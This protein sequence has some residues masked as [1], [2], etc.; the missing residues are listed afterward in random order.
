MKAQG[1]IKA[2]LGVVMGLAGAVQAEAHFFPSTVPDLDLSRYVGKWY[3]VESTQPFFQKGCVCNTA[4]YSLRDDGKI[5][6]VNSCNDTLP[7]GHVRVFEAIGAPS[8]EPGKLF[9]SSG[10]IPTFVPNYWVVD[11]ASDY[12]YAVVSSFVRT[13]IWILSRT[14]E[15]SQETRAA[16]YERLQKNGF[17]PRV[18]TPTLQEGCAH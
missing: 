2:L 12:S 18:L 14:P 15:I 17:D 8:A 13:P 6:I 11:V 4:E 1:F 16:I 3:E 10:G 7:E 9:V 5:N